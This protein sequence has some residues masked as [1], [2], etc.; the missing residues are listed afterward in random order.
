MSEQTKAA[1][2]RAVAAESPWHAELEL[3]LRERPGIEFLNLLTDECGALLLAE[4][5]VPIYLQ[6]QA[7]QMLEW[8]ATEARGIARRLLDR[9]AKETK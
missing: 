2:K 6:R 5:I 4:G 8:N 7:R 3:E 1:A 9:A